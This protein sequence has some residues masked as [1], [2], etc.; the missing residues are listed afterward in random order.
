MRRTNV[1]AIAVLVGSLLVTPTRAAWAAVN[2]SFDAGVLTVTGDA[3]DDVIIVEC[4]AIGGEVEVNGAA[5]DTGAV[6]C[7]DVTSIVVSAGGGDDDVDLLS[8]RDEAGEFEALTSASIDLGDGYDVLVGTHAADAIA[9]GPGDD[10]IHA[11]LNQGD[12]VDGGDGTDTLV[13]HVKGDVTISDEALTFESG[14][15]PYVSIEAVQLT[16]NQH[17][18]TFDASA[19]SGSLSVM[20]AGGKDRL[21]AGYG[22]D[23]LHGGQGNDVLLGGNGGDWL[24]GDAG[25]DFINAHGGDDTIYGMRG[26]DELLGDTGE[27]MLDGGRGIDRCNGGDG[28][29]SIVGCETR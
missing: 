19:F 29:D 11:N 13:S 14:A 18:Q 23:R 26:D 24:V 6:A 22:A 16:G 7:T 25:D 17:G 1:A 20:A 4:S 2:S 10:R 5:P 15:H 21:F 12:A 27:D 9:G 3:D 28:A 8:V